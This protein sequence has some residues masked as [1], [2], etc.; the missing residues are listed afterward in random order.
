MIKTQTPQQWFNEHVDIY[1]LQTSVIQS[2]ADSIRN[3]NIEDDTYVAHVHDIVG[4]ANGQYIPFYA[5]EYFGY[6][7]NTRNIEQYD[8]ES[9]M[10]ELDN[11]SNELSN[12]INKELDNDISVNFGYWDADGSY[13]LMAFMD[14]YIYQASKDESFSFIGEHFGEV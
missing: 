6:E 3:E 2:M 10:W 12:I 11:F 5:L 14:K 8:Y 1:K 7:L 9:V 13:C 4:G